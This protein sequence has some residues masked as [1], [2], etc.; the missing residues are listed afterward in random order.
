[1]SYYKHIKTVQAFQLGN[2]IP[3]APRNF[4]GKGRP[5]VSAKDSNPISITPVGAKNL[6]KLPPLRYIDKIPSYVAPVNRKVTKDF[7]AKIPSY[8]DG[9]EKQ[10][11]ASQA[12]I[13]KI[14][15]YVNPV[16]RQS[17][18]DFIA[19]IPKYVAPI[20]RLLKTS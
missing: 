16:D 13:D 9:K 12:Y 19:K 3:I 8:K 20:D 11:L 17:T 2:I 1:M 4:G 18:K 5:L 10:A 14:P 7:I 6:A 15:K